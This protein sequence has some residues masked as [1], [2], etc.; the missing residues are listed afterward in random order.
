LIQWSMVLNPRLNLIQTT[1]VV[2][3]R[4]QRTVLERNPY[5]VSRRRNEH[6]EETHPVNDKSK[7]ELF[8]FQ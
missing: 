4:G 3:T 1:W 5:R 8:F 2:G 6:Q 7:F